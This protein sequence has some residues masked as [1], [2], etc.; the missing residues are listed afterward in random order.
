MWCVKL[1]TL[2][3]KEKWWNSVNKLMSDFLLINVWLVSSWPIK[4]LNK[5]CNAVCISCKPNLLKQV[6]QAKLW[7][8]LQTIQKFNFSSWISE[9][10]DSQLFAKGHENLPSGCNAMKKTVCSKYMR[11]WLIGDERERVKGGGGEFAERQGM[12]IIEEDD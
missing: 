9:N 6:P 5:Q 1:S 4:M 2:W 7:F 10:V 11:D 3:F 12:N 8:W